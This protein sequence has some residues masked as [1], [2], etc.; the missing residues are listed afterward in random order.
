MA[1]YSRYSHHARRA[2]TH[3]ALLVQRFRHPRVDTGHLLVGVMLT[4]GSIGCD[5]LDGLGLAVTDAEPTLE[6]LTLPLDQPVDNPSNDAALDIALDLALDESNWLGHHYVGT[7]HLLLGLTRTN[8]GNASDV[9]RIL[10]VPPAQVRQQVRAALDDG[11]QEFSIDVLRRNAN[12]SELSRRVL[13]AA[14]QMAVAKDHQTVGLGHLLVGMA[15][16]RRSITATILADARLNIKTLLNGLNRRDAMFL[17]SVETVFPPAVE[18]SRRFGSH[19]TG[20]EHLLLAFVGHDTGATI[21]S[22]C[23]C[24]PQ[25]LRSAVEK[26]LSSR[27]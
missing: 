18:L 14:E 22:E 4:R 3:A 17:T 16:E 12:L 24:D 13:N 2:L 8:V 10:G 15:R 26:Q 20:T 25:V 1:M 19:Y 9:L 21:L 11:L 6:S 5:V 7:A 27:T 23:D